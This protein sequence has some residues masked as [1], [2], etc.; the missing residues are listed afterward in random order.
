[1]KI[2]KIIL[3]QIIIIS[4]S[5]E[6][7]SESKNLDNLPYGK[8]GTNF[9]SKVIRGNPLEA[10]MRDILL[11]LPFYEGTRFSMAEL[12]VTSKIE[13]IKNNTVLHVDMGGAISR[14][15]LTKLPVKKELTISAE[16][17]YEGEDGQESIIYTVVYRNDSWLIIKVS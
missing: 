17:I 2:K 10:D 7:L 16:I 12:L 6:A 11:S 8:V 1:M 4:T 15:N 9:E 13:P 3:S 5:F 14:I